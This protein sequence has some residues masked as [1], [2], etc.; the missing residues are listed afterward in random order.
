MKSFFAAL[1]VVSF[2][3]LPAFAETRF[4]FAQITK[5][6]TN[7]MFPVAKIE[8]SAL[9]PCYATESKVV[10]KLEPG[11]ILE[12]AVVYA[13]DFQPGRAHC[14][15]LAEVKFPFSITAEIFPEVRLINAPG[16][17]LEVV[18]DR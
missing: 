9:I 11:N 10:Q 7:H 17:S 3:T 5:A 18:R 6:V 13:Y 2:M 4:E 8:V 14:Q 16:V 1:L 12:V 15:S